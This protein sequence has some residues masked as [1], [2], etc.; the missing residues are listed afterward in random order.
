MFLVLLGAVRAVLLEENC[1]T[2]AGR[3]VNVASTGGQSMRDGTLD[4]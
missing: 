1:N 2:S 4:S 3:G